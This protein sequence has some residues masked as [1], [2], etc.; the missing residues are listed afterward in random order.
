MVPAATKLHVDVDKLIEL[1]HLL[2]G[3]EE[4]TQ[5]FCVRH[6]TTRSPHPHV[7]RRMYQRPELGR[8]RRTDGRLVYIQ[9]PVNHPF[10]SEFAASQKARLS[11][12]FCPALLVEQ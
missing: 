8:S 1:E 12:H 5:R 7:V 10:L 2:H 6:C 4:L 9:S 11:S 3:A